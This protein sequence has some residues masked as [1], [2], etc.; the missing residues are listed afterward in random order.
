ML[1]ELLP[2]VEWHGMV[3]WLHG[4]DLGVKNIFSW[5]GLD[6][7]NMIV[8]HR[9]LVLIDNEHGLGYLT[10]WGLLL[11]L[12]PCG[13]LYSKTFSDLVGYAATCFYFLD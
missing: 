1:A 5:V 8:E 6:E 11:S 7:P 12:P 9:A 10:G 13:H 2:V 4:F 3:W